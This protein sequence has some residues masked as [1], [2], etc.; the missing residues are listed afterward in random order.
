MKSPIN[1]ITLI[2]GIL[3]FW[4]GSLVQAAPVYNFTKIPVPAGAALLTAFGITGNTVYG[5]YSFPNGDSYGFTYDGRNFIT[6]QSP[7]EYYPSTAIT[8]MGDNGKIVGYYYGPDPTAGTNTDAQLGSIAYYSD[9][10][11]TGFVNVY[12]PLGTFGSTGPSGFTQ[13]PG[14]TNESVYGYYM[15][16]NDYYEH[17][18][19]WNTGGT[20]TPIDY[21]G[22][23]STTVR[24][25]GHG[26]PC[27]VG[28]YTLTNDV[29][30][31]HGF[32]Y[33]GT[34]FT[35]FDF[36]A[37]SGRIVNGTLFTSVDKQGGVA[38]GQYSDIDA[39]NTNTATVYHAFAVNGT[40]AP[41]NI[42]YPGA[43]YTF[44]FAVAK[45][46]VYGYYFDSKNKTHG[47]SWSAL[48]G[49]HSIDIP[50]ANGTTIWAA[51]SSK[52]VVSD[53]SG[54]YY[55]AAPPAVAQTITITG[56]FS[57]LT[58]ES[59][60]FSI[61][62]ISSSGLPVTFDL[63][64][65]TAA[66]QIGGRTLNPSTGST[67]AL[68]QP[69]HAGKVTFVARQAGN[70]SFL[71]ATKSVTFSLVLPTQLI[72]TIPTYEPQIVGTTLPVVLYSDHFVQAT[73]KVLS[74]PAKIIAADSGSTTLKFGPAK[75][76]VVIQAIANATKYALAS[77]PVTFSLVVK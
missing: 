19:L 10:E 69:Y 12:N 53:N 22:A 72:T 52:L 50:K 42:D 4:N 58:T 25:G 43:S 44:P 56:N 16:T 51:S 9:D 70:A 67:T 71:P 62:A 77:K 14:D 6:V 66:A 33:D 21:P 35:S 73:L 54:H 76:T 26:M 60:P 30:S 59:A 23:Q 45:G 13:L 48:G 18:F 40:N 24:E 31:S 49:T 27:L 20:F 32:T 1:S 65:N 46:V 38:A 29:Q 39:T 28:S 3:A 17:F 64:P 11:S 37:A 34:N 8:A 68:V 15:S 75:G 63:V 36:P 5:N 7:D 2:F 47:F 61:S 41:V 57:G 74:G 55:L